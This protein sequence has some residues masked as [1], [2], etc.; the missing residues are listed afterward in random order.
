MAVDWAVTEKSY[1]QR[2]A[3][4]LIGPKVYRYQQQVKDT[5][6]RNRLRELSSQRWRFDYRRLH[7]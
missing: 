5:S 4:R 6:L 2:K 1:S 3:C 7:L